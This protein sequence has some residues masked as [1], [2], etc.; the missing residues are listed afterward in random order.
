MIP[1]TIRR[2]S[3]AGEFFVDNAIRKDGR[4]QVTRNRSEFCQYFAFCF[5]VATSPTASIAI[6]SAG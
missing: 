6:S 1:E 4:L 2:Q 3:F 5:D